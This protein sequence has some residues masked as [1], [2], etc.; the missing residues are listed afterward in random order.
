[1]LAARLQEVIRRLFGSR[2]H[3][4]SA[5]GDNERVTRGLLTGFFSNPPPEHDPHRRRD[6][7]DSRF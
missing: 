5:Q 6:P 3:D 4:P 1:M 2:G 7:G